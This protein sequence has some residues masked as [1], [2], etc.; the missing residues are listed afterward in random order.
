MCQMFSYW[1]TSA[2]AV[3][4]ENTEERSPEDKQKRAKQTFEE[5]MNYLPGTSRYYINLQFYFIYV[6][7]FTIF[8]VAKQLLTDIYKSATP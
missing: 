3:F 4:C 6:V 1:W 7:L 8:I 2:D 5:M